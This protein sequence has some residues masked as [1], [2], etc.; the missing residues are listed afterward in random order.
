M[1]RPRSGRSVTRRAWITRSSRPGRSAR[2]ASISTSTATRCPTEASDGAV[3][4]PGSACL[5]LPAGNAGREPA[6]HPRESTVDRLDPLP[7]GRHGP[8]VAV[9]L[10]GL[11]RGVG[12]ELAAA[13]HGPGGE[14]DEL[15]D[16]HRPRRAVAPP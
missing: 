9:A 11:D 2:G 15:S 4:C 10:A 6:Q 14:L 1:T 12:L 7:A 8:A 5:V 16:D 3:S 13:G